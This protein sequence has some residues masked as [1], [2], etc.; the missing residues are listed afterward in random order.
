MRSGITCEVKKT[1]SNCD[2]ARA[3]LCTNWTCEAQIMAVPMLLRASLS[4]ERDRKGITI[5]K[6]FRFFFKLGEVVEEFEQPWQSF[7]KP[8]RHYNVS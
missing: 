3:T 2:Y 4:D 8:I 5:T 7:T 1:I 6:L